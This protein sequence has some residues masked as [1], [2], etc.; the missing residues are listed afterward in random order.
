MG[1]V[2]EAWEVSSGSRSSD[3]RN[4]ASCHVVSCH[5]DHVIRGWRK[6][7]EGQCGCRSNDGGGGEML[8]GERGERGEGESV[9]SQ[10]T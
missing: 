6:G 5:D 1:W 7:G 2:V 4:P 10:L 9:R 3:R 8:R